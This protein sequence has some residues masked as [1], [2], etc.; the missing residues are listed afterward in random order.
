MDGI[1]YPINVDL[2]LPAHKISLLLQAEL[3]A[4]DF[5]SEEQH[6]KH[7]Q[8][9]HQDKNI[10]FQHVHRLIRCLIDCKIQ[11]A[12]SVSVRHG[13]EL[14]RSFAARGWD[15]SPLQL[16]Q[17]DQLGAVAVRKLAAAGILNIGDLVSTEARRLEMIMSRHPPF[18][19]KVLARAQQFPKLSLAARL[20]GKVCFTSLILSFVLLKLLLCLST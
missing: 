13:L 9:Y 14:V 19:S 18:G 3:G 12:D 8:Q 17:I 16:K 6:Q 7:R 20:I 10:I 15:D 11:K 2:A 5:P 4:V 1:R